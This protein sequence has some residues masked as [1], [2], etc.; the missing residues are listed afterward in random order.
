MECECGNKISWIDNITP[1]FR[2]KDEITIICNM[3][4]KEHSISFKGTFCLD[5]D[6]RRK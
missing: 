4:D 2:E 5:K 1:G 3:C 6:A